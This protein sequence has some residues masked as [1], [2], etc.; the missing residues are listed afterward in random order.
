MLTTGKIGGQGF[1]GVSIEADEIRNI[2]D[3]IDLESQKA[4]LHGLLATPLMPDHSIDKLE[5]EVYIEAHFPDV[6]DRN[7]IE[8]AFNNLINKASQY[9]NRR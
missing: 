2:L 3:I 5:Q 8:E 7:E 6:Q 9:A 4:Q 1:G